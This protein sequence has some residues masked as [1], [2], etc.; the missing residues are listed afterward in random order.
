MYGMARLKVLARLAA[1]VAMIIALHALVVRL[2]PGQDG[3]VGTFL[4]R[5]VLFFV[6]L[7]LVTWLMARLERRPV[8]DFGLPWRSMFRGQFWRGTL[9]GF[10][11]ITCLLVVMRIV[12]VFAFGTLALHG[13][14]IWKWAIAWALVFILVGLYEEYQFRGYFLSTLTTG[15]GFWPAAIVSACAF[16]WAHYD[17]TGENL[18]GVFQAGAFGLLQCFILRRSGNLWMPIGVHAAFDW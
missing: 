3:D 8:A 6:I 10:G 18:I 12:G 16:G 11:A 7:V 14:D 1:F 13:L 15:V 4:V 17:N 2:T 9:L 5:E